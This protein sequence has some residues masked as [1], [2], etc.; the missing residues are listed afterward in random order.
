MIKKFFGSTFIAVGFVFFLLCVGF[1]YTYGPHSNLVAAVTEDCEQRIARGDFSGSADRALFRCTDDLESPVG[2]EY[3]FAGYAG[4]LAG[5]ASI[6]LVLWGARLWQRDHKFAGKKNFFR[7]T[8]I[9]L[10][11]G[12]VVLM[13]VVRAVAGL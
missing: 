12:L 13:V 1:H 5:L 6:V 2:M 10:V 3:E 4:V 7:G 11:G 9:A 8:S